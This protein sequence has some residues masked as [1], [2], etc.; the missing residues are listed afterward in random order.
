MEAA[1]LM[2]ERFSARATGNASSCFIDDYRRSCSGQS[3]QGC[4]E[5]CTVLLSLDGS[6][7]R[8]SLERS[9]GRLPAAAAAFCCA[10]HGL[11]PQPTVGLLADGASACLEALDPISLA[12]GAIVYAGRQLLPECS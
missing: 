10:A 11:P 1:S 3:E 9:D 2:D 5:L 6:Q 7:V 4:E 12:H 8:A